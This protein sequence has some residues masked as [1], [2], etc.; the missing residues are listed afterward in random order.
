MAI[1]YPDK[2]ERRA[3]VR[4]LAEA[5]AQICPV[6]AAFAHL[7]GYTHPSQFE[8]DLEQFLRDAADAINEHADDLQRHEKRITSIEAFLAPKTTVGGLALDIAFHTL[9]TNTTGRGSPA[10]PFAGLKESFSGFDPGALEEALAELQFV[11]CVTLDAALGSMVVQYRPTAGMFLA[12]DLAATGLD[13]R[14]DAIEVANAW[15]LDGGL[16]S[17]FSLSESLGWNPR[18]LNPAVLALDLALPMAVWSQE[19][20][21]VWAHTQIL[22]TPDVRFALR[23]IVNTGRV[24]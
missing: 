22:M 15:L 17:T 20:H 2:S 13:T 12:F 19:R 10:V 1:Q 11:G 7:Y 5:A 14:A 18:R 23:Q 16:T 4:R 8:R 21:P 24:D 9:Q 3:A 6:T